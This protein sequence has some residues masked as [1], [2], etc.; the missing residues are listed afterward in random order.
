MVAGRTLFGRRAEM[1]ADCGMEPSMAPL[2]V[3]Q[4]HR[5]NVLADT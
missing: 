3:A 2:C 1:A 5:I 4:R